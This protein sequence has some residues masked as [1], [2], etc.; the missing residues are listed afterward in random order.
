MPRPYI[1]EVPTSAGMNG[2]CCTA[3]AFALD[4]DPC[5]MNDCGL[6]AVR[7]ERTKLIGG[8]NTR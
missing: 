8:R 5:L 1:F 2:V 3:R 7:R 6:P 4:S